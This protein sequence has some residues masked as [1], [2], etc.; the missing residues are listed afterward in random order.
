[1]LLHIRDPYMYVH[2]Y[3]YIFLQLNTYVFVVLTE[4]IRP[5]IVGSPD[6]TVWISFQ[7]SDGD[8]CLLPR[9][10]VWNLGDSREDLF[11]I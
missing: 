8:S 2:A 11:E 9:K 5:K 4:E 3:T 7:L 10:L 6:Q 1:M